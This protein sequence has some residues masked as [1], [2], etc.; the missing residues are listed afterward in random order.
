MAISVLHN[1]DLKILITLTLINS[2]MVLT[3]RQRVFAVRGEQ[4][5]L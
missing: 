2:T 4:E 1:F 3:G 5:N